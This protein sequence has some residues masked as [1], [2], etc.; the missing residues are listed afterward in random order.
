MK[1]V[2]ILEGF[3]SREELDKQYEELLD[4]KADAKTAIEKAAMK[5]MTKIYKRSIEKHPEGYW[6]AY[7]GKTTYKQFCYDAK[8]TLR[9]MRK[10][11]MSWRVVEGSISD[12][13]TTWTG[14]KFVKEN[15][16]VMKYLWAT[17]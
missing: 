5:E 15:S 4:L 14:Y 2:W 10:Q 3:I 6:L 16:G 9:N 1:K 12:E 8:Q 17:L 13:A 11:K 7:Q